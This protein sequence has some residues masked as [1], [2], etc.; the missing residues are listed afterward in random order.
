MQDCYAWGSCVPKRQGGY[1]PVRLQKIQKGERVIR[2]NCKNVRD[3]IM[4]TGLI[5]GIS[6][7]ILVLSYIDIEKAKLLIG[8]FMVLSGFVFFISILSPIFGQNFCYY[9]S[10]P[11]R[12]P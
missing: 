9:H 10:H 12:K 8:G 1:E 5:F 7:C 4:S 2:C 11:W 3:V 6:L